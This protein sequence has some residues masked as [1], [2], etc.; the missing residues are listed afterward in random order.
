MC[1]LLC[2]DSFTQHDDFAMLL[3]ALICCFFIVEWNPFAWIYYNLFFHS[4][5]E[6]NL[7]YFQ[8]GD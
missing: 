4:P 6:G 3:H 5:I 7:S 1:T 8:F 2:L